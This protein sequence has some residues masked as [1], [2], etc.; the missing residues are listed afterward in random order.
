MDQKY[1]TPILNPFETTGEN[2]REIR[3][4]FNA[5]LNDSSGL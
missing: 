2:A 4:Y 3:R 5:T 1:R